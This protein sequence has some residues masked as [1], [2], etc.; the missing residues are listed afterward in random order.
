M[1]SKY[2]VHCFSYTAFCDDFLDFQDKSNLFFSTHAI[3]TVKSYFAEVNKMSFI[4]REMVRILPF[5]CIEYN[6][7]NKLVLNNCIKYDIMTNKNTRYY[8]NLYH[9]LSFE[10][11]AW[12]ICYSMNE[13]DY[14]NLYNLI[15]AV[16]L[17]IPEESSEP[18]CSDAFEIYINFS[19]SNKD[20]TNVLRFANELLFVLNNALPNLHV[21]SA[22]WGKSIGSAYDPSEWFFSKDK[23]LMNESCFIITNESDCMRL[24]IIF[25]GMGD[26]IGCVRTYNNHKI[27]FNGGIILDTNE[28]KITHT[29]CSSRNNDDDF[30]KYYDLDNFDYSIYYKNVLSESCNLIPIQLKKNMYV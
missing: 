25:Q 6:S 13:K 26:K 2:S 5:N 9:S 23:G 24:Q 28:H 30:C 16:Y 7:E 8:N 15:A 22:K 4:F 14:K 10:S 12:T 20:K 11:I 17:N 29:L 1:H 27:N 19:E 21:G 18:D 3:I